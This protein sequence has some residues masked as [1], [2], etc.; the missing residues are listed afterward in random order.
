[1]PLRFEWHF[2]LAPTVRVPGILEHRRRIETA[3]CI[4]SVAQQCR[5][6]GKIAALARI[7]AQRASERKNDSFLVKRRRTL[8]PICLLPKHEC[9]TFAIA[10]YRGNALR[11]IQRPAIGRFARSLSGMVCARRISQ[12]GA[13]TAACLDV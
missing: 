8:L 5:T 12:G 6:F 9:R 4:L 2:R 11:E 7:A 3:L 13:R 1:M 10:A